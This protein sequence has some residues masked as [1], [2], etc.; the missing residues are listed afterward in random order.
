VAVLETAFVA[1]RLTDRE[2]DDRVGQALK[3]GRSYGELAA[4]TADIPADHAR[5][6]AVPSESPPGTRPGG[7]PER[8]PERPPGLRSLVRPVTAAVGTIAALTVVSTV[9]VAAA[10]GTPALIVPVSFLVLA[11]LAIGFA[12]TILTCIVTL[13]SWLRRTAEKRR[14]KLTAEKGRRIC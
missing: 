7:R 12:V 8:P 13:E 1:G 2:L 5:A 3:T 6:A 14:H 11:T 4:L 10:I 9:W